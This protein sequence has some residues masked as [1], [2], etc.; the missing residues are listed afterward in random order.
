M[1][2]KKMCETYINY[3]F[4]EDTWNMFYM[5]RCHN[6]ITDEQWTR[7]YNKFKDIS[8]DDAGNGVDSEGKIVY[9]RDKDGFLTAL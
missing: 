9:K 2:F 6:L 3:E 7:F 1:T 8:L 4:S 5:M